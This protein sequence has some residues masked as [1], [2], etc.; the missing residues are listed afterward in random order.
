VPNQDDRRQFPRLQAPVFCRPLGRPFFGRRKAV[1]ISLGGV[2]LFADEP[3]EIG[4][5]LELE[6]FLPDHSEMTCRVAV[7]W[8]DEL[9]EG[10]PARYDVGV[11]FV[12]IAPADQQRLQGVLAES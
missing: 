12:D 4:D 7:V 1:D 3:P 9:P 8:V 6:L 10:S 5:R 2:R 11:K